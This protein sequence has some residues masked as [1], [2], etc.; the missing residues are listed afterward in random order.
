M[1]LASYNAKDYIDTATIYAAC[2]AIDDEA[3]DYN[4]LGKTLEQTSSSFNKEVL[5]IEGETMENVICD[6]GTGI[7]EIKGYIE[8]YTATIRS[9]TEA[10]VAALQTE[11]NR[12]KAEEEAKAKAAAENNG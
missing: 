8:D 12:I 7:R 5:S 2:D 11:L 1:G 6:T 9:Q 3:M 4:K 10:A